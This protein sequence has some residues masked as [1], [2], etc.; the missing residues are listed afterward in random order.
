M[1]TLRSK[2]SWVPVLVG[3]R[4]K[5][6]DEYPEESIAEWHQRLKLER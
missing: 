4:D 2:A 3:P 5:K 6:F 1:T